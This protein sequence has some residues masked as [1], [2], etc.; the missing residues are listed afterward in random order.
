MQPVVIGGP[1][2]LRFFDMPRQIVSGRQRPG[3]IVFQNVDP[4]DGAQ[5]GE[6]GG[7]R[8]ARRG[9]KL[10]ERFFGLMIRKQRDPIATSS[11]PL[12]APPPPTLVQLPLP[13]P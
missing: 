9:A 8:L 11:P 1:R 4:D 6:V 7:R 13:T 12:F 5:G 10:L 2:A 3:V